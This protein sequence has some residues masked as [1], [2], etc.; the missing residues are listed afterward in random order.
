MHSL[1]NKFTSKQI[2]GFV[3]IVVLFSIFFLSF[4]EGLEGAGTTKPQILPG[5]CAA[6]TSCDSCGQIT[7]DSTGSVCYWCGIDKGCK[8]P[9]DY[10]DATTC[11]KGCRVPPNPSADQQKK[12]PS[13][14][15]IPDSSGNFFPVNPKTPP[16]NPEEIE[17]CVSPCSWNDKGYCKLGENA[18]PYKKEVKICE[19]PCSWNSKGDCTT[20]G[21]LPCQY[22]KPIKSDDTRHD[23]SDDTRH[24]KSDDTRHDKSDDSRHDKSD[25]YKPSDKNKVP[26]P[27]SWPLSCKNV[28]MFRGKI[29][30]N[31]SDF[32]DQ[33]S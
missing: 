16:Y 1:F 29:Y 3:S 33:V 11:A 2:L 10:Y 27:V 7:Q 26:E 18:C 20:R 21:G 19:K 8:S 22:I 13:T 25:D 4:R 15:L 28:S 31:P 14:D 24:D 5:S 6:A 9:T 30:L 32:L 23:K 17:A 12:Y